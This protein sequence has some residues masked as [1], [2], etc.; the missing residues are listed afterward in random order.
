[1]FRHYVQILFT[2]GSVHIFFLVPSEKNNNRDYQNIACYFNIWKYCLLLQIY[3]FMQRT[4]SDLV[5][6]VSCAPL[7]TECNSFTHVPVCRITITHNTVMPLIGNKRQTT[8]H[9]TLLSLPVFLS[10]AHGASFRTPPLHAVEE[11]T[12]VRN[13]PWILLPFFAF[14]VN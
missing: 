7:K 14:Y 5:I 6:H 8:A 2:F 4:F 9:S 12:H 3:I 13:S 10:P 1:M 11:S